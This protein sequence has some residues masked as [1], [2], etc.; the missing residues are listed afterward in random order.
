MRAA[1]GK[2]IL[3]RKEDE[4]A[5]KMQNYMWEMVKLEILISNCTIASF[6]IVNVEFLLPVV[7]NHNNSVPTWYINFAGPEK[8]ANL[9]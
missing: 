7:K 1:L 9:I 8:M 5:S 4:E 3:R 6:S 2:P